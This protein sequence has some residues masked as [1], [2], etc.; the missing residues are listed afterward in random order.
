M[1]K[2]IDIGKYNVLDGL[3]GVVLFLSTFSVV[4]R[5]FKCRQTGGLH[6]NV[7]ENPK[8]CPT[9]TNRHL[10]HLLNYIFFH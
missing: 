8:K 5:R 9:K 3:K 4:S 6:L 1:R 7:F 2:Y 10:I